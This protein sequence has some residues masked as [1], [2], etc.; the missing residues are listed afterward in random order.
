MYLPSPSWT[1]APPWEGSKRS[2]L[3][4]SCMCIIFLSRWMYHRPS[5]IWHVILMRLGSKSDAWKRYMS[6]YEI[7]K[8]YK[9]DDWVKSRVNLLAMG[10][11]LLTKRIIHILRYKF[12]KLDA[13]K[14]HPGHTWH[15]GIGWMWFKPAGWLVPFLIGLQLFYKYCLVPF[16]IGLHPL[17]I[18]RTLHHM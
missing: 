6:W 7:W 10:R 16:L 2:Y 4:E 11:L 12:P 13:W 8:M 15:Q 18:H 14:N 17:E 5:W 9:Y 3:T 1:R